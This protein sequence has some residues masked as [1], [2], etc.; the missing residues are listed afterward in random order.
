M[1][2]SM[3]PPDGGDDVKALRR[4]LT[5]AGLPWCP[6]PPGKKICPIEGWQNKCGEFDPERDYSTR[7]GLLVN[8]ALYGRD[9]FMGDIDV[10]DASDVT[11]I[12]AVMRDVLGPPLCVR[13]RT[14]SARRAVLYRTHS[15]GL[16]RAVSGSDGAIEVFTGPHQK[17]TCFGTPHQQ[18][19]RGGGADFVV[20][21]AGQRD[22]WRIDI[23]GTGV[24]G[25]VL[26]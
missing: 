7:H 8:T 3:L 26:A 24:D 11:G 14:N 25:Q 17:L 18:G 19:D 16:Y 22:A 15:D 1:I 12:M 4:R 23:G 6:E 2:Q 21:R 10:D 5:A 13:Y 9:L 20:R